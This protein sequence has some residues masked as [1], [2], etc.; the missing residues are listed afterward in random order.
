MSKHGTS[1]PDDPNEIADERDDSSIFETKV[2]SAMLPV[3]YRTFLL[4][5]THR[6]M[7]CVRDFDTLG[8]PA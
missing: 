7:S 5:I 3:A 6:S 4:D 2:T 8:V 1:P